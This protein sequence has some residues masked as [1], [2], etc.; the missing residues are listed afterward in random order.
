MG[1]ETQVTRL[2][3]AAVTPKHILVRTAGETTTPL[4][5]AR[6]LFFFS[7]KPLV[8]KIYINLTN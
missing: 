8:F 6:I 1:T 7:F 4:L 5:D 3:G 2:V